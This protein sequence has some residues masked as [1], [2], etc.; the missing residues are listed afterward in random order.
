MQLSKLLNEC[1]ESVQENLKKLQNE[2][3][4]GRNSL[5]MEIDDGVQK[6]EDIYK[7]YCSICEPLYVEDMRVRIDALRARYFKLSSVDVIKPLTEMKSTLQNLDN[8]SIDTL[9]K[10]E[11]ELQKIYV[12]DPEMD[13]LHGEVIQ[14]VK[15]C[16]D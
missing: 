10:M 16:V 9:H 4:F 1:Y 8:I 6:L 13:A 11:S 14:I 2:E 12:S 15:V 5:F 7:E 3:N